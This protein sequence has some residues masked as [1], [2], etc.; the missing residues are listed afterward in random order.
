MVDQPIDIETLSRRCAPSVH[1]ETIDRL[2]AAEASRNP[3]AIG[4]VDGR[5]ER[6]PTTLAEAVA[7][8]LWLDANKYNFSVGLMQ[9]NKSN[10]AKYSLT[11]QTAFD[12]CKNISVGS[13]I[14][15]DCYDRALRRLPS[16]ERIN[17]RG[18]ALGDALS[19]YYSGNFQTGYTTG[20]VKRILTGHG[21]VL[22]RPPKSIPTGESSQQSDGVNVVD[23]RSETAFLF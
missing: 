1:P 21:K 5:L 12:P 10:F 14:L 7:T 8:A 23:T 20:Y 6:Q 2:I 15:R 9:V 11:I 16:Q 18:T 19:C 3:Y 13:E 4:I 17:V 22:Q